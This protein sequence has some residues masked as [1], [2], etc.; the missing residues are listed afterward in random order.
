MWPTQVGIVSGNNPNG[1]FPFNSMMDLFTNRRL[2]RTF[3]SQSENYSS[4]AE[5]TSHGKPFRIVAWSIDSETGLPQELEG[6]GVRLTILGEMVKG[7][8][9]QRYDDRFWQNFSNNAERVTQRR[10]NREDRIANRNAR[11]QARQ[12]RKN[13]R[14][15]PARSYSVGGI[16]KKKNKGKK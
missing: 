9:G 10:L 15:A 8:R 4:E 6:W 7:D 13:N 12:D 14:Q 3:G 16:N 5:Y 2:T 1:Q 11:F